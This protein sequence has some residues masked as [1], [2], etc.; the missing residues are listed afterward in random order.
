[1]VDLLFKK[2][3]PEARIPTRA[4]RNDAGLDLYVSQRVVIEPFSLYD[5]PCG[6]AVE[7]PDQT[8]AMVMAR[9]ST[10]RSRRL[11]VVQAVIDPGFRGELFAACFSFN[12]E[13]VTVEKDERV[14]QLVLFPNSTF[15]HTP[16]ETEALSV[17][18]RDTN[19]FGSSGR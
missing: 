17:S 9:S 11:L 2:L 15:Y 18:M 12:H 1:M 19:G 16:K 10:V 5:V 8:F 13:P 4:Y 14:A 3:H 7:L 6:V